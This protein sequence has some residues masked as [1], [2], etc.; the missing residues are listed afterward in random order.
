MATST[1]ISNVGTLSG[2]DKTSNAIA[3]KQFTEESRGIKCPSVP[4]LMDRD[5]VQF[6]IRMVISEL[7]EMA[8]TVSNTPE[9]ALELVRSSVGVDFNKNYKKTT[10]SQKLIGEQAD[11]MVDA[12]Y[13]M[14]NSAAKHGMNLSTLFDVVHAAN[15]AKRFPDGTFHRRPEDGKIVK[16][17]GWT[18]PNVDGE[19]ARQHRDGSW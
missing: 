12:W 2:S 17:P 16:P 9:E 14:L 8:Q 13:Y 15:M 19:I 6:T 18:E 10:N 5:A 4:K 7:V 1:S 11:A 3:V